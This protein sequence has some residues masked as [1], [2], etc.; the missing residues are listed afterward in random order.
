MG[1]LADEVG[2]QTSDFPVVFDCPGDDGRL[3]S[4][5]VDQSHDQV[6]PRS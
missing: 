3:F 1:A 6:V 2:N 5:F 4:D